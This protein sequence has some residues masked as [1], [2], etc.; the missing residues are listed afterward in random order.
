MDGGVDI[1]AIPRILIARLGDRQRSA[2]GFRG[3]GEAVL[4]DS[5]QRRRRLEIGGAAGSSSLMPRDEGGTIPYYDEHYHCV[6]VRN[7][8]GVLV[9]V[10]EVCPQRG[11]KSARGMRCGGGVEPFPPKNV[12]LY[13]ELN[14]L[15][16]ALSE[17]FP[18]EWTAAV[19]T[20]VRLR[21]L[22]PV[23]MRNRHTRSRQ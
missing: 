6:P 13:K 17:S 7:R 5:R 10:D 9:M 18:G 2:A 19:Q 1:P 4:W 11:E 14:G 23:E 20:N 15:G 22:L 16:G 12:A 8:E 21:R 3:Y